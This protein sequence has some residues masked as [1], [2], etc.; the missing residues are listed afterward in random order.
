MKK[1]VFCLVLG[2]FVT[3]LAQN[4]FAGSQCFQLSPFSDRIRVSVT[5]PDSTV[6][7]NKLITGVWYAPANYWWPITGTEVK[8]SD[9][10]KKRFSVHATNSFV[11][12]D[13]I[14]DATLDPTATPLQGPFE[15]SCAGGTFTNSGTLI[16][17]KCSTLSPFSTLLESEGALPAAGE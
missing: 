9:G 6:P 5:T 3:I 1:T 2:C 11:Y 17:V 7:S 8:D 15:M 12:M 13:C 10:I 16:K 4:G 14:L